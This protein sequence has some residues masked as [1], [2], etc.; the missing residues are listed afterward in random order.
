MENLTMI[1]LENPAYLEAKGLGIVWT[2]YAEECSREYIF[3][4]GFN[5]NSGYVYIA[6]EN[7]IS[8]CSCLGNR[9]EYLVTNFE[10]GEESFFDN[11][12]LAVDFL[13]TL[14]A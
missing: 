4:V 5:S 6:L 13:E 8:I 2:A 3:E 1:N 11:Y 9:V 7:G 12:T 14:N 10:T